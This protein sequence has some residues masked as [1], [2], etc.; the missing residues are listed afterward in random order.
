MLEEMGRLIDDPEG[1][2]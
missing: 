2:I 1:T